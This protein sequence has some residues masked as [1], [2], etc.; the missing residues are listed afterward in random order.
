MDALK[1]RIPLTTT[2]EIIGEC[3][4]RCIHCYIDDECRRNVLSL[5]DI[6]NFG[7]QITS[8]GCLYVVLTGG[9]VLLHPDFK[10]IYLYFIKK[11][12]CV[13][14]FTSGSL[15][16]E[17]II[18]LFVQYPPKQ[19]EITMYGANNDTYSAVIRRR[20]HDVVLSNILKLKNKNINV[21][22]KMFVTKENFPDFREIECFVKQ[23]QLPFKFDS[24]ILATPYSEEKSHQIE[25]KKVIELERERIKT[26]SRFDEDVHN[27]LAEL[28]KN[29]LYQCGAGR[30]SCWLKSNN[31]LR[32]CNFLSCIDY[33]M[34][35]VSFADAW[36]MMST[37]IDES[38]AIESKCYLCKY[39]SYC[40]YCPAKSYMTFGTP[41][42]ILQEQIFCK[43]AQERY[44]M[45][46]E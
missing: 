33:D 22:V 3:N 46:N 38:K 37:Y 28:C 6:E 2:I 25:D 20:T 11:G 44:V 40:D 16:D 23:N 30:S 8:M 14:V 18:D 4:F 39:Q 5:E 29:K 36:N 27:T 12:L 34:K 15:I 19:I 41:T 9:E 1:K 13:S 43:V 24:T 32:M 21:L 42:M 17:S 10:K 35:N 7:D 31:H 45:L 26:V